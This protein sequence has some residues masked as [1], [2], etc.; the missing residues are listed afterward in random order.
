MYRMYTV[1]WILSPT[2]Y[3]SQPLPSP[4]H[5]SL[6]PYS[7]PA[8]TTTPIPFCLSVLSP[9]ITLLLFLIFQDCPETVYKCMLECWTADHRKRPTFTQVVR[10]LEILL[11]GN[12]SDG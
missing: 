2:M 6:F 4:L 12:L 9:I 1:L 3:S 11:E 7:H 5:S 10:I 8:T